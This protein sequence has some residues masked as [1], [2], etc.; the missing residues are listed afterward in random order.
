MRRWHRVLSLEFLTYSFTY[1]F[2]QVIVGCPLTG[3]LCLFITTS[4]T[5]MKLFSGN[6]GQKNKGGIP[7]RI[8]LNPRHNYAAAAAAASLDGGTRAGDESLLSSE[9]ATVQ[10]EEMRG[11]MGKMEQ[12]ITEQNQQMQQM[13]TQQSKQMNLIVAS[14]HQNNHHVGD[15]GIDGSSPFEEEKNLPIDC[16]DYL[17]EWDQTQWSVVGVS[18]R[19]PKPDHDYFPSLSAAALW[20]VSTGP[21]NDKIISTIIPCYNEEGRDLERTM[22]GLSRQVMPE[23]WHV[24]AVIVMDGVSGMSSSMAALLYSLFGVDFT[25]NDPLLNP[26]EVLPDARTII[27]NPADRDAALTRRP[28]M[29]GTVGGYS[30]VVKRENRRKANSQQWWLGPHATAVGCKYALATD[31]GTYFE[32]TTVARLVERLDDDIA[33]HAVTGTQRTMPADLQGDGDWELCYNP[34]HFLLRQL[35]RFE[36]EVRV[37]G[38]TDAW[39]IYSI[40]EVPFLR[41]FSSY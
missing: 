40:S 20:N 34:F 11:A 26:F 31:C 1:S 7:G 33:T 38:C 8:Q 21:P 28:V 30:L 37:F 29:E 6:K 25:S 18:C 32:R 10:L 9:A 16:G 15:H 12:Q 2:F 4:T 23:G 35:Q 17:V 22:R 13:M 27:V 19:A 3:E 41:N 39:R 14:L 5:T 24:E 36:F